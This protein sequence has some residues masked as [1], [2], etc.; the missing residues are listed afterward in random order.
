[1]DLAP[2]IGRVNR[3]TA[4]VLC[5]MGGVMS[6]YILRSACVCAA[7]LS[8]SF[9]TGC[10]NYIFKSFDIDQGNESLSL[11]AKQRVILV[12]ERGGRMRDRKVVCAEPSPDALSATAASFSGSAAVTIP[13]AQGGG[14][15]NQAGGSG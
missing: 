12:T 7:V 3:P 2:A 13:T 4:S 9:L 6:A 10:A 5:S 11:D 8:L 14:A 1:M 15:G